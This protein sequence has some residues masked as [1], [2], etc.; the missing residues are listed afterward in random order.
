M[1]YVRSE[2]R[3]GVLG[4]LCVGVTNN[5]V[6][7]RWVSVYDAIPGE[8]VNDTAGRAEAAVFLAHEKQVEREKEALVNVIEKALEW[9]S[10]SQADELRQLFVKERA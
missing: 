1:L 8:L 2:E 5:A 10:P 3:E 9:L 6:Y 4:H 7:T